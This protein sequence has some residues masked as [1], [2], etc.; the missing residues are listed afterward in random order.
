MKHRMI[1][2]SIIVLFCGLSVCAWCNR[3]RL[4]FAKEYANMDFY[5][6]VDSV[7][8]APLFD[9]LKGN[10][11]DRTNGEYAKK[12][13][14][15][16]IHRESENEYK[17]AYEEQGTV[18]LCYVIKEKN[19]YY[20]ITYNADTGRSVVEKYDVCINWSGAMYLADAWGNK[21]YLFTQY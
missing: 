10:E 18:F 19:L 21:K 15:G 13:S 9:D 14:M 2:F 4:M 8:G 12:F 5:K 11:T 1:I 7:S 20:H 17:Y 3:Y 16:E 6:G